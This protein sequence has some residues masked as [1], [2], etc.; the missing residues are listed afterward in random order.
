[1]RKLLTSLAVVAASLVPAT[2][3]LAATSAKASPPPVKL[4]GKVNVHGTGT[5][6]AGAVTIDQHDYFFSP[7]FVKVPAGVTSVSVTVTNMG[8]ALHSF[9]VPAASISSDIQP[10]SSMTFTVP[11]SG[12]GVL[13][14]C[15]FHRQ[16]GMQG[17][18]FTKKGA[19]ISATAG[20]GSSGGGTGTGTA[21][22]SGSSGGSGY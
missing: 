17:A 18:F 1:V 14:Y 21:T 16:L 10:G 4:S 7:T 3:A 5:A 2:A 12:G 19:K 11:V 8:Q 13:F 22:T 15:R 9:T 6:T 20:T